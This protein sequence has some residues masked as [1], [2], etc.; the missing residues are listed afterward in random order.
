V[1]RV[2]ETELNAATDNPLVFPDLPRDYK[3][4]SCGNFHGEPLAFAM[5]FLSIALTELG[6]VAERRIFRLMDAPVCPGEEEH[7]PY[8]LPSCLVQDAPDKE[9]LNSGFLLA[10]YTAAALV[11]DCK[12]LAHPD[13]VDSIPTSVSKEDH[14][15]MSTNA[16][17]HAREIVENIQH[18][19]AIE[20]LC[21]AQ[22]LDFRLA[23]GRKIEI[24]AGTRQAYEC[25]RKVIDHLSRDRVLYYDLRDMVDLV[26]RGKVVEA[27]WAELGG[28]EQ[29]RLLAEIKA[30]RADIRALEAR[31][32]LY[33]ER[34]RQFG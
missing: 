31:Q 11:S 22:A 4:V 14:V 17:R 8:T 30:A 16:A 25:I 7:D 29:E 27:T 5:D 10:Q 34:L 15:S 28:S 33:E 20:M 24:G 23:G 6:S 13:S 18:V 19:I 12:T 1:R 21:A 2:V 9:G 32:R 3:P 26:Q